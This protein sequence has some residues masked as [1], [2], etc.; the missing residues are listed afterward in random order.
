MALLRVDANLEAMDVV[1][2]LIGELDARVVIRCLD[3]DT[4]MAVAAR[5]GG[6]PTPVGV[7]LEVVADYPASMVA[8]D[9]ATLSRLVALDAVVV[10]AGEA[11]AASAEVVKALLG[12]GPVDLENDVVRLAGAFNRPAPPRPVA[13]WWREGRTL[14]HGGEV[15][16][17][18]AAEVRAAVTLTRYA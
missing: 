7:W 4:V 1:A 12:G 11:G 17:E 9:A 6:W 15:L 13:V 3:A 10:S 5:V 2:G 16:H 8:R 18:G 14:R